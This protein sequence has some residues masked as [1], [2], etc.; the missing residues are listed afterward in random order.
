VISPAAPVPSERAPAAAA[1]V[2]TSRLAQAIRYAGLLS[3]WGV[4][5]G[6]IGPREPARIWDRH[7]LNSAALAGGITE[8][9]DV[10]DVGSGAGLPGIPLALARP[11]LR[12]RL[13]EPMQ[14]RAEFLREVLA[15][16]EL[17]VE[18]LCARAEDVPPGS[19]DV[20]V[21]RAVAPLARLLPW[22]LPL[23]RPGGTLLALKGRSAEAE[24]MTA[25][26]VLQ[27]WPSAEVSVGTVTYAG[28]RAG[29]V[30]VDLGH[31]SVTPEAVR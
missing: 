3:T 20:V 1:A 30:R 9:A 21:A 16:L 17:E 31:Q 14:R 22:T 13:V 11:D 4:E 18:V 2:F 28:V 15:A 27:R 10:V 12:I 7:V 24:V 25:R 23:L 19:A 6:L 5:R 26:P 29:V 8:H